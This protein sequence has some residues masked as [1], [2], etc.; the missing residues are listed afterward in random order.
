[1]SEASAHVYRK[2]DAQEVPHFLPNSGN[3]YLSRFVVNFSKTGRFGKWLRW[4]L[5]KNLEPYI[6]PCITR[7]NAMNDS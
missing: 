5:E 7:N 4:F 6:H 1:M 2:I 3:S